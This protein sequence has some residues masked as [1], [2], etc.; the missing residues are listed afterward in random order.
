VI[1][2]LAVAVVVRL[3]NQGNHLHDAGMTLN[4]QQHLGLVA[5]PCRS[6]AGSRLSR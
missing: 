2:K 1:L 5:E 3:F 6:S 4:Q